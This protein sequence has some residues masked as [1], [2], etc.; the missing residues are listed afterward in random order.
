MCTTG[1]SSSSEFPPRSERYVA[2]LK[3]NA[4]RQQVIL[5]ALDELTSRPLMVSADEHE[6]GKPSAAGL[7]AVSVT[8][9]TESEELAATSRP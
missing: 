5:D 3:L 9:D 2:C 1:R 8:V 6:A 7:R 4:D